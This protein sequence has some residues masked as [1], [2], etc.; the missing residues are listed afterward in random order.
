MKTALHLLSKRENDLGKQVIDLQRAEPDCHVEVAD[1]QKSKVDYR[2][3]LE[4]IFTADSVH[5]W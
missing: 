5:I 4:K 3:L 1:L 2:E